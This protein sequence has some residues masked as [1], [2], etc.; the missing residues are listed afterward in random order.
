MKLTYA[1][2]DLMRVIQH[3]VE[4]NWLHSAADCEYRED[5]LCFFI[6]RGS[7]T[8]TRVALM[9]GDIFD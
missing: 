6:L 3:G 2:L 1:R 9:Y 7:K 4:L 5:Y 8:Y